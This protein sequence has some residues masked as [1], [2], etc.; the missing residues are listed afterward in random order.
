MFPNPMTWE[1]LIQ[2]LKVKYVTEMYKESKWNQFLN[3]K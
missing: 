2:E 1:F 3:L